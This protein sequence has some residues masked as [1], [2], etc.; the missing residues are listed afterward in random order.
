MKNKKTLSIA[1]Y[2]NS[3]EIRDVIWYVEDS[4]KDGIK[5]ARE[6]IREGECIEGVG[7]DN[8][9]IEAV[10]PVDDKLILEVA[11]TIDGVE[12]TKVTKA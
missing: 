3:E 6:A 7:P 4:S 10:Y 11:K 8:F 12:I 5:Q 1:L 9:T 2:T